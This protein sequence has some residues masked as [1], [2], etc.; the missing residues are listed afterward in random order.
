MEYYLLQDLIVTLDFI[1]KTK[2][3]VAVWSLS[4][5]ANLLLPERRYKRRALPPQ[6]LCGLCGNLISS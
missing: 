4:N 3:Q 2:S 1:I 6:L 5:S